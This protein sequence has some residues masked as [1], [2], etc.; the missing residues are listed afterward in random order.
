MR[1]IGLVL[2]VIVMALTMASAFAA[3][4]E[5]ETQTTIEQTNGGTT[6]TNAGDT[7]Q[8][9]NPVVRFEFSTGDVVTVELYPD[10]APITVENFLT[11]VREGFYKGTVIHRVEK[12]L[13]VQGGGYVIKNNAYTAKDATH[14]P[15]KGEFAANGVENHV[16]HTA[17]AISMARTYV[18]DSA[19]SQFFFCPAD[20][21]GWDGNYAAFG[22]V[23]DEESLAA[24][25][26][27]SRYETI[28]GTTYPATAIVIRSVAV[29][30]K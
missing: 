6:Q 14:P 13:V 4:G 9:G 18:A 15:I 1:K 17:G 16:S 21:T 12:G 28:S 5:H 10:E 26:R 11:Y 24:I 3:C 20:Y 8:T 25:V 30:E 7:A 19:T 22:H 23:V 29:V 2:V 27:L